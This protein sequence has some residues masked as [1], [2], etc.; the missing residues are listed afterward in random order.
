MNV[1]VCARSSPDFLTWMVDDGHEVRLSTP[2]GLAGDLAAHAPDIVVLRTWPC[3]MHLSR[4]IR[5]ERPQTRIVGVAEDAARAESLREDALDAVLTEPLSRIEFV[6]RIRSLAPGAAEWPSVLPE[7]PAADEEALRLLLETRAFGLVLLDEDGHILMSNRGMQRIFRY[8]DEELRQF[9]TIEE[10]VAP[11]ERPIIRRARERLVRDL[12]Q[13]I[14]ALWRWVDRSGDLVDIEITATGVERSGGRRALLVEVREV[15]EELMLR[16]EA[17]A[18]AR[19]A[20][21]D[22]AASALVADLAVQLEQLGALFEGG[23]VIAARP[24]DR[25]RVSDV[26]VRGRDTVRLLRPMLEPGFDSG[27]VDPAGVAYRAFALSREVTDPRVKLDI[28][29]NQNPPLLDVE[30]TMLEE[31]LSHLLLLVREAVAAQLST[32]LEAYRPAI[33]LIVEPVGQDQDGGSDPTHVLIAVDH[34]GRRR[35]Q[36]LDAGLEILQSR[37]AALGASIRAQ[38][39]SMGQRISILLPVD[40][41]EPGERQAAR[42]ASDGAGGP[43]ILLVEDDIQV[44]ELASAAFGALNANVTGVTTCDA[45]LRVLSHEPFDVVL[46]AV[47]LPDTSG[48]QTLARLR[49]SGLQSPVI[50]LGRFASAQDAVRAGAQG[51]VEDPLNVRDLVTAVRRTLQAAT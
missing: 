15:G 34:N 31:V 26:I 3:R 30:R 50:M 39:S 47:D 7:A 1:L 5:T 13:S 6:R 43:S 44:H 36:D 45:A 25:R 19:H 29:V 8:T 49:E 40:R 21:R 2:E 11:A 24:S 4:L 12:D 9:S 33:S 23:R 18:E 28:R 48:W 41:P 35:G 16:D 42:A 22:H 32:A 51:L 38:A 37:L 27:G 20:Q 10:I 14:G 17:S 46:L